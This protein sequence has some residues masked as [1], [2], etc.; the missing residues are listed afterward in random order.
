MTFRATIAAAAILVTGL[1]TVTA[2]LSGTGSETG[3]DAG[4][5]VIMQFTGEAS[6]SPATPVIYAAD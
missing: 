2:L 3:K 5:Y 6:A 4:E 1:S